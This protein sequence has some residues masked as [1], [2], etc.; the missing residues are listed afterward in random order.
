MDTSQTVIEVDVCGLKNFIVQN[1]ESVMD[2]NGPIYPFGARPDIV[3][4]NVTDGFIKY[5]ITQDTINDAI[6]LSATGEDILSN[7]IIATGSYPIKG[8]ITDVNSVLTGIFT[9]GL[10]PNVVGDTNIVK[11]LLN[12]KNYS[13]KNLIG[14]DFYIGSKEIFCKQWTEVFVNLNWK[15]KPGNFRDY[16]QAYIS[17]KDEI[18]PQ[19]TLFGLD[20][21]EFQINLSVLEDGAWKGE[22][23]HP[24]PSPAPPYAEE[25]TLTNI[26]TGTNNRRLFPKNS[27]PSFCAGSTGFQQSIHCKKEFFPLTGTPPELDS[28]PVSK[29]DVNVRNGFLKINLQNQDFLHNDYAYVLARQMNAA[30]MLA[31]MDIHNNP[32]KVEDAIYYD[33]DNK[34]LVVFNSN[35][36][37]QLL[38][39]SVPI[40]G[41]VRDDINATGNIKSLANSHPGNNNPIPTA[42]ANTI[43]SIVNPPNIITSAKFESDR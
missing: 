33:K 4:F 15:D 39:D 30:A 6:G 31:V 37:K 23:L 2:V 26:V 10:D 36:I 29:Y 42:N 16:Y 32:I 43:R 13:N 7:L 3:D 12:T 34:A 9:A 22:L 1:D 11:N 8:T 24:S 41:R 5:Y 27:T 28:T 19:H 17:K 35:E 21:Q 38:S 14:P 20:D 18:I 40:A 25:T